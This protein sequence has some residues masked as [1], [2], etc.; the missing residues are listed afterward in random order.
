AIRQGVPLAEA[1]A[2]S[3]Q[4]L[5][6][7]HAGVTN[8]EPKGADTRGRALS[9]LTCVA[10]LLLVPATA[11]VY[12]ILSFRMADP[13]RVARIMAR[14]L[15]KKVENG[16][17]LPGAMRR[18]GADYDSEEIELVRA[19]EQWGALPLTLKRFSEFQT[20]ERTLT[21][22][23]AQVTYPL[24]LGLFLF[25]AG[26]FIAWKI[27]PKFAEV[28]VE[29][30]VDTGRV[31][32]MGRV[33][34]FLQSPAMPLLLFNPV[35][36]ILFVYFVTRT[37]MNGNRMSL[38]FF[39]LFALAVLTGLFG[40]A[41]PLASQLFGISGST[42]ALLGIAVGATLTTL[43]P[44][45]VRLAEGT[46]LAFERW[47][48]LL[49]AMFPFLR[50]FADTFRAQQEARWL[51]A[52]SLALECGVTAPEAIQSAGR[53]SVGR[54]GRRSAAVVELVKAGHSIGDACVRKRLLRPHLN[55][56]LVLI[57]WNGGFVE[58]LRHI[59]EDASQDAFER[60]NRAGR[61]AEVLAVTIGSVLVFLL[62]S[63]LYGGL[64]SIPTAVK[65]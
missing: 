51:A 35:S 14:R 60:L 1:L 8:G 3:G 42:I 34:L 25:H 38:V 58:N 29:L 11:F 28:L 32:F 44:V 7:Y 9:S 23:G 57:D 61:L 62:V 17:P 45:F 59:A 27:I 47:F 26:L 20:T 33:F 52:L 54:L 48:A 40:A 12:T 41:T 16:L 4:T 31:A 49:T 37:L 13:D 10:S 56:R 6:E 30:S 21:L 55:H 39:L 15:L 24:L 18:C 50:L 64:F 19:G 53:V 63:A 2:M 65:Y 46:V 36:Y 5:G 22:Q 43:F